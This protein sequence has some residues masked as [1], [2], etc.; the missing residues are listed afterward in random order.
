MQGH[1]VFKATQNASS[2]NLVAAINNL[3]PPRMKTYRD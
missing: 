1:N 2:N 3:I